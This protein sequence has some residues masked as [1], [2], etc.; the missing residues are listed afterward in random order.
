M[1]LDR[2][3]LLAALAAL[4]WLSVPGEAAGQ[5][6]LTHSSSQTVEPN[7]SINCGAAGVGHRRGQAQGWHDGGASNLLSRVVARFDVVRVNCR[8]QHHD[9]GSERS[10]DDCRLMKT[11]HGP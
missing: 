1:I 5:L 2:T 3:L 7:A 10:R 8:T 4:L 9:K 11:P 6:V